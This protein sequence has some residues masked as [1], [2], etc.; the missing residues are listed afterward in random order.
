MAFKEKSV[1][2]TPFF[3]AVILFGGIEIA[4][5]GTI[6]KCENSAGKVIYTENECPEGYRSTADEWLE[7]VKIQEEPN[8]TAAEPA[9]TNGEDSSDEGV[10]RDSTDELN[11]LEALEAQ[12][13]EVED[14]YIPLGRDE[15]GIPYAIPE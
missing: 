2:I 9:L 11:E 1:V 4:A 6:N 5:A 8:R 14:S 7:R 12:A 13:D 10:Q 3:A 15:K